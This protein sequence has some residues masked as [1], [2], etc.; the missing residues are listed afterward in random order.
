MQARLRINPTPLV[1]EASEELV[2][3]VPMLSEVAPLRSQHRKR[4]AG[5]GATGDTESLSGSWLS[6]GGRRQGRGGMIGNG[7]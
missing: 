7:F 6:I 5:R 2:L 1:S 4:A 3:E